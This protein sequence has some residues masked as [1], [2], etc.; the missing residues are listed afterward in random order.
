MLD[1][2]LPPFKILGLAV[3]PPDK[4]D[5]DDAVILLKETRGLHL[6]KNDRFISDDGDITFLGRIM[7]LL[8]LDVRATRLILLGYIFS[9]SEECLIIAAG[10]TVQKVFR[11]DFDNPLR[12]YNQKLAFADGSCS[13][14]IAFMHAYQVRSSK[15]SSFFQ[16][17]L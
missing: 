1:L 5:I 3:N 11:A 14:L 10:V 16:K 6:M 17:K 9:V 13:D 4:T 15:I 12:S 7:D 2:G 8:P